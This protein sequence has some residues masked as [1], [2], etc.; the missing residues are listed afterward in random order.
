[1]KIR[2]HVH[3]TPQPTVVRLEHLHEPGSQWISHSFYIT[4]E[5][6]G[7]LKAIKKIL[8]K[9]SGC[10]MF[11]IGHYGSGKSHFLAYLTQQIHAGALSVSNLE[12]RPISLLHYKASQSLE[13]IVDA[14][15]GIDSS[16]PDRRK[17]WGVITQTDNKGLVLLIDELS[18]FL[19]SK[20]SVQ[21]FNEDLRFLQFLGEWSQSH[22]LWLLAA[23][24]EQIE[25]TG[26][27]EYDLYRKIKDRYPIR[28][29]ISPAH[30]RDLIARKL[31]IKD[32]GYAA[33]VETL[34][35]EWREIYPASSVDYAEL[36]EVY[37]LH[38]ATMQVLEEVRD[39]FSQARGIVDF[40]L[41]RLLGNEVRGIDPFLDESW[42]RMITP[43]MIVDHFS[44]LFEIQPEF[45]PIAQKLL[46]YFRKQIPVLFGSKPQQDLAW[47]LLKILIL[48]HL[49][50]RR[51]SLSPEEAAQWLLLSVSKIEPARNYEVIRKILDAMVGNG[52]FLKRR[53]GRYL[54]DLED[55]SQENWDRLLGKTIEE[56]QGQGDSIFESLVP[57]LREGDFDLF[58]LPRD[59]WHIRKI[60]WFFHE[61]DVHIY[62]GNGAAPEQSGA[63]LQIAL[64]WGPPA[65][66]SRCYRILPAR[67]E[68][69]AEILELAALYRLRE[70]PLTSKL[71]SRVHERI[72]SR[73]TWFRALFRGAYAD[74]RV[75]DAHGAPLI[76]LQNPLQAGHAKW[77]NSYC[78]WVLRQ[79]FPAFEALAPSHGPLSRDAYRQFI[80]YAV[81]KDLCL[82]E[83]PE[84]V[85]LIREAYLVPMGL[86]LRRGAAYV[87]SPKLESHDLVR[88]IAPIIE[89]QPSPSRIYQNLGAPIYGLVPDQIHLLLIMLLIQGE[90]DIVKGQTS[91]REAYET[92]PNPLQYDK[93]IPGKGLRMD[94]IKD[95]QTFCENFR[96]PPPRQWTV[97]AQKRAIEQLRRAAVRQR[98]TLGEF[99]ARLKIQPQ[100]EELASR[101]EQHISKWLELE[102]GENEFQGFEHFQ[103]AAGAPKIFASE[104]SELASLPV[105]FDKLMREA[106]RYQHLFGYPCV[107]SGF[108]A[109]VAVSLE[110]L[111]PCPSLAEPETLER[112]LERARLLYDRYRDGYTDAHEKYQIAIHRHPIWTYRVLTMARSRHAGASDFARELEA[113][114]T[115]AKSQKC[116]GI[117]SLEF[118]PLCRC[119]YDGKGS[120]VEETLRTFD[121]RV[122]KMNS[123]LGLFFRQENVRRKVQDWADQKIEVNSRTLSYLEGTAPYPDTENLP[124]FDQFLSGIDL[125][126]EIKADDLLDLIGRQTWE[127]SALLKA[128]DQFF[129][130]RG[131]RVVL[132]REDP[133]LR[134]AL[135]AWCV[136]QALRHGCPLPGGFTDAEIRAIPSAI[137][138]E[139]VSEASLTQLENLAITEAGIDQICQW[140]LDGRICHPKNAP[141]S[142]PVAAAMHLLNP[143]IPDSADGLARRLTLL[144][145]HNDRF[146]RLR[147]D[148]WLAM[149]ER[150]A[151]ASLSQPIANLEEILRIRMSSQWI[152]VDALGLPLFDTAQTAIEKSFRGWQSAPLEYAWTGNPT[153]TDAFYQRLLAE[154]FSKSFEKANAIDELIHGRKLNL[155]DLKSLAGIE[156]EIAFRKIIPRLNP[157]LPVIIFGDHGFRLSSDGRNFIHGGNS[158]LER[159]TLLFRLTPVS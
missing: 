93:I 108:N 50:P 5:A 107:C 29:L 62:F 156:L 4:P 113:L 76:P 90:I 34:I 151:N 64:P 119:G 3:V 94:Q 145:S 130:A 139:W 20:P 72:S 55:D 16:Q 87:F 102:K 91:Y 97:L 99:A 2:D 25:H 18:E 109:D 66:D 80:K 144:Y 147:P 100:M 36:S 47:R 101:L 52:A 37:P 124:L 8:K 104:A 74:A 31:L 112:W 142:G 75:L 110:A 42:G 58:S 106:Q 41:T 28:F 129:A 146:L 49:S 40:V 86:M 120:P 149:L 45:L 92:L 98:D 13:S 82:E 153:N 128:L 122:E 116:Q 17:A 127:K 27:I 1:M 105:R 141:D 118:Q 9:S 121:E 143:V 48:V 95:L 96:I 22:R 89:H 61:R 32:S 83:A 157:A 54:L 51:S 73:G 138:P 6:D 71:T 135:V 10:G 85:R 33:A 46:P 53:H 133:A 70:R 67:L 65:D 56:L 68:L 57:V 24:Q 131:S 103:F 137:R 126:Q 111:G 7:Y 11:L 132:R 125:V 158:T 14:V 78:E 136:E 63:A 44:D 152:V 35:A 114:Q 117:S 43:D 115:K 23:L 12:V 150:F 15:L 21:S 59:R 154:G 155:A 140:L 26:D 19:R 159:L 79:V 30:V 81:E 84:V 77:I 123:E 134:A 38:P 69:G 39:R 88:Q 60:Q 148:P